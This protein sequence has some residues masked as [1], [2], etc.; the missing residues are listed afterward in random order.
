MGRHVLRP[1]GVGW[2]TPEEL[3]A[4]RGRRGG[5]RNINFLRGRNGVGGWSVHLYNP[6]SPPR[7]C[8]NRSLRPAS[9]FS[10]QWSLNNGE[11]RFGRAGRARQIVSQDIGSNVA[12]G[13]LV[14]RRKGLAALAQAGPAGH[15]AALASG[16]LAGLGL[17]SPG[18]DMAG[19]DIPFS[20]SPA[21]G[22]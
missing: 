13:T 2:P 16:A 17:S 21:P 18:L 8:R 4:G 15:Y 1:A 11:G 5:R 7:V 10:G 3:V 12:F 22:Y 19:D 6:A 9:E 20:P 14:A